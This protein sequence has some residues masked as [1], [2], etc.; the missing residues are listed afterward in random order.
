[1]GSSTP[2]PSPTT[3]PSESAR[4]SG[5]VYPATVAGFAEMV[6]AAD[7]AV[8]AGWHIVSMTRLDTHLG[9]LYTREQTTAE[10]EYPDFSGEDDF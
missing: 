1:M 3:T 5:H 7:R 6:K 4:V 8:K 9:I 10:R 2:K